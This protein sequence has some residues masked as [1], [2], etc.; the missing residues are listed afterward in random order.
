MFIDYAL[1]RCMSPNMQNVCVYS[2]TISPVVLVGA[3]QHAV[4]PVCVV[5]DVLEEVRWP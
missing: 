2:D 4:S 1:M 5:L 3:T